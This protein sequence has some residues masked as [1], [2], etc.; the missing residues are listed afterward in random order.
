MCDSWRVGLQI[1]PG[2]TVA[3]AVGQ[4]VSRWTLRHLHK[5]HRQSVSLDRGIQ[6]SINKNSGIYICTETVG[7]GIILKV[8]ASSKRASDAREPREGAYGG[9]DVAVDCV[10]GPELV[11]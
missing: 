4:Y 5:V 2:M 11:A 7:G 9:S 3:Y 6:H 1:S 10:L 8:S